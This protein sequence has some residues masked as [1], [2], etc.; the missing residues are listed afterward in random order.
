M[1]KVDVAVTIAPKEEITDQLKKDLIREQKSI[2][3]IELRIDQRESFEIAD[4]ERLFKTLKDL[5]LDVQVLVT[6]RTSVQGGKGQKN[7]NTYYEFLQDLIQI[8]GYDMVDIEWDEAQ[9][10][11]LLQLIV[12]AQSAGL[13]VVLS[14]HDF[15]KTP[16]LEVLKFLYFKMNK[17]GADIVKLAVMPNEKQDVLNL[18]EALAT[19]SESIEAKPVGISMSHLGLIS[20]T[21]QG[22]FGG[23]IS[24]G[25]LGTPQAP[26]QIHVGQ[27][28]ELLNIYEIN[29]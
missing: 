14:Q 28:K 2:D 19:A 5:Q 12:Q 26:G 20:R 16:N 4:L 8:Q 6:Y 27:L 22:V 25:C 1:S 29:K 10:E 21:A 23:I 18:L 15:D 9:T 24:Y 7:G 13:K 3:I 11:I 17:L